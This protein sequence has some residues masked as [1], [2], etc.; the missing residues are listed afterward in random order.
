MLGIERP[1][2]ADLRGTEIADR[3]FHGKE[4]NPACAYGRATLPD[5]PLDPSDDHSLRA[6][7]LGTA[8]RPNGQ[9]GQRD[10]A[11]PRKPPAVVE[12]PL[13]SKKSE[14]EMRSGPSNA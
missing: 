5:E 14:G 2:L 7:L 12:H 10:Q 9:P 13:P 3:S 4:L 1:V 8:Q 11:E 6:E